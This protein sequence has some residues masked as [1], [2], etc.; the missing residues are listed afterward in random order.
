MPTQ[1]TLPP[2]GDSI[3][4]GVVAKI[5]VSAGD[6][7]EAEQP[8][9]ELE[10][11]KAVQEVPSTVAGKVGKILIKEGDQIAIGAAIFD[12]EEA[13]ASDGAQST[14]AAPDQSTLGKD[15]VEKTT[16]PQS[17]GASSNGAP[18]S[19]GNSLNGQPTVAPSAPQ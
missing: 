10:T 3:K 2:M 8:V 19:S 15:A 6:T 13:G 14:P 7:I 12:L 1:F 4:S 18:A 17:K 11:D 9:L 5:F 16:P